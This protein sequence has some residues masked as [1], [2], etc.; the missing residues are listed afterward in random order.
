M[1]CEGVRES[2]VK[3]NVE[4]DRKEEAEIGSARGK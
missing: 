4:K 1:A 3:W 2:G